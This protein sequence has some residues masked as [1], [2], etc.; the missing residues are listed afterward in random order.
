MSSERIYLVSSERERV[1]NTV[2]PNALSLINH[3]FGGPGRLAREQKVLLQVSW[4]QTI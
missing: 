2:V 3:P 1:G 4:S